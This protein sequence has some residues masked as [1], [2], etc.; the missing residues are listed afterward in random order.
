MSE[1]EKKIRLYGFRKKSGQIVLSRFSLDWVSGREKVRVSGLES[2]K[3]MT[4]K[5]DFSE[6]LREGIQ[7]V[8]RERKVFRE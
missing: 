1:I 6:R 2:V 4:K 7:R 5:P 8:E 3:Y